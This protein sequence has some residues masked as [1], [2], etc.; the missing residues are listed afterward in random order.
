MEEVERR[1]TRWRFTELSAYDA[2]RRNVCRG[3]QRE[4]KDVENHRGGNSIDRE[5]GSRGLEGLL[6]ACLAKQWLR[7]IHATIV[8]LAARHGL[9]R[10]LWR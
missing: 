3:L 8:F 5:R 2:R 6:A 7:L 10:W 9:G 4:G 1:P